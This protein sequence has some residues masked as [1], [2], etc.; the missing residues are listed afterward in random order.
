MTKEWSYWVTYLVAFAFISL[1][2]FLVPFVDT[3]SGSYSSLVRVIL[4][5][6]AALLAR[7]IA[8]FVNKK[9]IKNSN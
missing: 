2:V 7:F 9:N 1:A 4:V 8:N 5:I 3:I 6:V